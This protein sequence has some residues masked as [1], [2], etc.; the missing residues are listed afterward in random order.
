MQSVGIAFR[1]G[2]VSAIRSAAASISSAGETSPA[3]SS[4][5]AS[6][7][8]RVQ[9]SPD[10]RASLHAAMGDRRHPRDASARRT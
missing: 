2:S 6:R 9:S 3:L 7:A 1:P 10:T 8:V 5:T 4:A